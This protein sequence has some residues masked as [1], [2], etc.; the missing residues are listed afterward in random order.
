[1]STA[2]AGR[3]DEPDGTSARY[4]PAGV[5]GM[6]GVTEDRPSLRSAGEPRQAR[7]RPTGSPLLMK[8]GRR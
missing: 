7:F 2:L 5:P 3:T 6:R 1:M 8:D 4:I